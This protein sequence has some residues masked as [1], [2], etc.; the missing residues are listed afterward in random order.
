MK[1]YINGT[2]FGTDTSGTMTAP[3]QTLTIGR[4]S[5]AATNPYSG[6]IED[7]VFVNDRAMT[8]TEV[9]TLYT[10]GQSPS[11]TTCHIRFNDNVNDETANGNNLTASNITYLADTPAS[12]RSAASSRSTVANLV[13][14]GDFEY[15][16]A[17]TAATTSSNVYINGTAAGTTTANT[18]GW[19]TNYTN[20]CSAQ[21]D[22][23]EKANGNYSLKLSTT[24]TNAIAQAQY[25]SPPSTST[26]AYFELLP[27]TSYTITFK[28]KTN[29]VSGVGRGAF[30]RH[31][32]YSGD[33][34]AGTGTDSTYINTTT[35]WTDYSISFT[36]ASTARYGLIRLFTWGQDSSATLI[37][38][39]WFDD[40]VL[41]K[42]TPDARTT[43]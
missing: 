21:F 43:A 36:T 39:A 40:I 32:Q 30:L 34:V 19:R 4:R 7:F 41:T 18:Y 5:A 35:N 37:M 26:T 20:S 29:Y 10:S 14:N 27:S 24:G 11:D 15:A 2:L 33:K 8:A 42:T 31:T 25:Y 23:A 38:D 9:A 13:T 6:L 1:W 28:M 12:T 17:F 22:S 3:T 16:P